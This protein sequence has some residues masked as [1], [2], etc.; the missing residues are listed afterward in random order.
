MNINTK[1]LVSITDANQNFSKVAR[2][3]DENGSVIILKN[4]VPR[5]LVMEF[6]SAEEEQLAAD[7]DVMS[8]S[9]RLIEK[10]RQAYEVLAK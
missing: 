8:I 2:L 9:K 4:N 7:E 5:Y 1:N 3:V 6:S 10:N